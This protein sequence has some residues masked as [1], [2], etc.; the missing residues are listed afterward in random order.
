MKSFNPLKKIGVIFS[1]FALLFS[2]SFGSGPQLSGSDQMTEMQKFYFDLG[3]KTGKIAGTN[4][5]YQTALKDFKSLI[6]K[7]K[8][9]VKAL[10]AGKYLVQSGKI[11][12]PKVYKIREGNSYRIEI[13]PSIVER[14]FTPEDLFLLPLING[15]E[16]DSLGGVSLDSSSAMNSRGRY[17]SS[18]NPNSFDLPSIESTKRYKRPNSSG[19]IRGK[20]TLRIPYKSSSVKKFLEAYG[21]K[22]V[23]TK[24]GYIVSFSNTREKK[25]FCKELTGDGTCS[26]LLSQ[27]DF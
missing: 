17:N 22:Y 4:E 21:S 16:N 23:D 7:Y 8:K 20:T 12:Y 2:F 27:R 10:E 11:T 24:S 15:A 19:K 26:D 5:G 18:K 25:K 6:K 13:K 14:E 9:K 3:K 1:L